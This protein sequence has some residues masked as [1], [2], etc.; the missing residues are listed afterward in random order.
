MIASGKVL[1]TG[2]YNAIYLTSCEIYDPSTGAWSATGSMAE[3][4]GYHTLTMLPSGKVLAAAGV[5]PE[6]GGAVYKSSCELYDPSAGTWSLTGS[7]AA[8]RYNHAATLLPSGKV[9]V[10]GSYVSYFVSSAS[11]ELYDPTTGIW[12]ATGSMATG[13]H[14][15]T[16]TLLPSGLVLVTGGNA[17]GNNLVTCELYNPTAANHNQARDSPALS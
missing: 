1:V 8:T 9:L 3:G 2:G 7:L 10:T 16:S 13:R 15:H 6:G 14:Y 5:G 12:S 11:C 17:G 4:R